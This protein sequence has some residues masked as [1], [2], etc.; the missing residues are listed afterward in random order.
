MCSILVKIS[1][2]SCQKW[3][4][5][6]FL[7]ILLN[8][9]LN[10]SPFNQYFPKSVPNPDVFYHFPTKNDKMLVLAKI[11]FLTIFPT[12]AVEIGYIKNP[13]VGQT[14]DLGQFSNLIALTCFSL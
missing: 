4:N 13:L 10:K 7:P 6:I 8:L 12:F 11:S 9:R 3:Q 14:F 2:E 5:S 1:I